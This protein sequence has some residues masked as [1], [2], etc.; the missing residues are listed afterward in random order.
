MSIEVGSN[1]LCTTIC[2]VVFL[3]MNI[4]RRGFLMILDR[5]LNYVSNSTVSIN[6]KTNLM[7]EDGSRC[8]NVKL[9]VVINLIRNCILHGLRVLF[10]QFSLLHQPW[11]HYIKQIL[12]VCPGKLWKHSPLNLLWHSV[13]AVVVSSKFFLMAAKFCSHD[14][15]DITLVKTIVTPIHLYSLSGTVL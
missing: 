7:N 6:I 3:T 5:C 14:N 8:N 9:F 4:K 12:M 1:L 11:C 10:I 2:L 15:F 13:N